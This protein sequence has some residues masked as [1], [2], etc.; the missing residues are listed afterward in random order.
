MPVPVG[1]RGVSRGSF[2]RKRIASVVVFALLAT[3]CSS[4][5]T[6]SEEYQA[7]ESELE[8]LAST[9]AEIERLLADVESQL[10]STEDQIQT[11]QER[12]AEAEERN[13]ELETVVRE[14]DESLLVDEVSLT[15]VEWNILFDDPEWEPGVH[16]VTTIVEVGSLTEDAVQDLFG[17][18]AWEAE[19]TVV[20]LC[21]VTV[22]D[23]GDG[24]VHIGDGYQTIEG[25]GDDPTAMQDAFDT[26]GAPDYACVG[27]VTTSGDQHEYCAPL[28][29][30]SDADL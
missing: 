11:V 5:V 21:S 8:D 16:S 23:V 18:L 27:V 1:R 12:L 17:S 10:A 24:Y 28:P 9:Q 7:L 6:Q 3:A 15:E 2:T 14:L 30:K 26:F 13:L 25:C 19:D 20:H 22:R 4:D 29:E